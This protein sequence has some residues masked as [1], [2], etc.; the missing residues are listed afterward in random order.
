M[1][2]VTFLEV[3]QDRV[4]L[5]FTRKEVTAFVG[6]MRIVGRVVLLSAAIFVVSLIIDKKLRLFSI[7]VSAVYN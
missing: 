3:L 7:L 1:V 5:M 2:T 6:S 4:G